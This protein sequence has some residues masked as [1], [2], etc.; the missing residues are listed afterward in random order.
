[1]NRIYMQFRYLNPWS[2]VVVTLRDFKASSFMIVVN[3][4]KLKITNGNL[5]LKLKF[6]DVKASKRVLLWTPVYEKKLVID[7]N[8]DI[9]VEN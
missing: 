4:A 1:M 5:Q 6:K 9:T 7:R 8:M 2:S 3:L